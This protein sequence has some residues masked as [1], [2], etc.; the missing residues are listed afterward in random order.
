MQLND[1]LKTQIL[2]SSIFLVILV[3][4]C[5][6]YIFPERIDLVT[7]LLSDLAIAVT[8]ILFYLTR[9]SEPSAITS[10]QEKIKE[11]NI[12]RVHVLLK[13]YSNAN[14]KKLPIPVVKSPAELIKEDV[15]LKDKILPL[16]TSLSQ[17]SNYEEQI[18]F[19]KIYQWTDIYPDSWAEHEVE[20]IGYDVLK[21]LEEFIVDK[22]KSNPDKKIIINHIYDAGCANFGQYYAIQA[23]ANNQDS[24]I[25]AN[26]EY[27]SQDLV[28]DWKSKKE[29]GIHGN[30]FSY[31]LPLTEQNINCDLVACTHTFNWM[32][33]NP[34]AIYTSFWSFNKILNSDG[35]CYVTVPVKES[36]PG[37]LDLLEKAASDAKF[38]ILES[39]RARLTHKLP[40]SPSQITTFSYLILQKNENLDQARFED[41]LKLSLYRGQYFSKTNLVPDE[42]FDTPEWL[43][44]LEKDLFFIL[45]EKS[46]WMRIFHS[47]L[48]VIRYEMGDK[49]PDKGTCKKKIEECIENIDYYYIYFDEPSR[50]EKLQDCSIKYLFWLITYLY[51]ENEQMPTKKI[52][53]V[54]YPRMREIFNGTEDI[55]V[56]LIHLNNDMIFR[57]LKNLF[58]ICQLEQIEFYDKLNSKTLSNYL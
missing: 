3:N 45:H 32:E 20:L 24:H 22:Q 1:N 55:R 44:I 52:V 29:T 34:I 17:F 37:M 19:A 11:K 47:A 2:Y 25:S 7:L 18:K 39:R 35:Y 53:E 40:N 30:F 10:E 6:F 14:I 41:L 56:H 4:L 36:Q 43:Q 9:R 27:S 57:L 12:S 13:N 16:I 31:P 33:K 38:K 54:I 50:K 51:Q 46:D 5:I 26:F 15:S 58:E 49:I 23:R 48:D 21:T 42:T 8:Y 28:E